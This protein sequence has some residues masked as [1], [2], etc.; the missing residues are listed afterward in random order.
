MNEIRDWLSWSRVSLTASRLAYWIH[1]RLAPRLMRNSVAK[2]ETRWPRQLHN[3]CLPSPSFTVTILTRPQSRTFCNRPS[4]NTATTQAVAP[5]IDTPVQRDST[6]VCRNQVG[7]STDQ[8]ERVSWNR[9][10]NWSTSSVAAR[11]LWIPSMAGRRALSPSVARC[12]VRPLLLVKTLVARWPLVRWTP[13]TCDGTVAKL[14]ESSVKEG[15]ASAKA[16]DMTRGML[17]LSV[18]ASVLCFPPNVLLQSPTLQVFYSDGWGQNISRFAKP[19]SV[20]TRTKHTAKP[21]NQDNE[22]KMFSQPEFQIGKK[23]TCHC[24]FTLMW[25]WQ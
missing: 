16:D 8:V 6:P 24:N 23:P 7:E 9:L 1:M 15:T 4:M 18:G 12:A 25:P 10:H 3:P 2:T 22:S 19:R 14:V 21:S 20:A 5:L 11:R 13:Q 17:W